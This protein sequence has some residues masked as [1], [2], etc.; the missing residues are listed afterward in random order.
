M[1]RGDPGPGGVPGTVRGRP[2]FLFVWIAW[3]RG[4]GPPRSRIRAR[5]LGAEI[6]PASAPGGA[7]PRSQGPCDLRIGPWRGAHV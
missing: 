2:L 6:L 5:P 3:G 1:S 4:G 7:Q